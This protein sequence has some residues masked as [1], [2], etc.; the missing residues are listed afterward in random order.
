MVGM[1]S[2]KVTINQCNATIDLLT[3][4]GHISIP[5]EHLPQDLAS[6]NQYR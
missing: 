5:G 4:G 1:A 2:E 3:S 6:K